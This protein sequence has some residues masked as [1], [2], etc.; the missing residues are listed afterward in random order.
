MKETHLLNFKC[1]LEGQGSGG[2]LSTEALVGAIFALS[3]LDS[4][5]SHIQELCSPMAL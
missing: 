1:M 3:Y 2:T 5:D 4:F